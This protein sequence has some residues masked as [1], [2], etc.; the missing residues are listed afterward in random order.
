[1]Q[2]FGF[3]DTGTVTLHTDPWAPGPNE[4]TL[5]AAGAGFRWVDAN[6]FALSVVYAHKLGDA[7]ATSSSDYASGRVWVQLSKFF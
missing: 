1:M 2:V 3:V 7:V 4:R 5:S 6:D